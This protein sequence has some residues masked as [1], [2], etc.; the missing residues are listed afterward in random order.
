LSRGYDEHPQEGDR[1]S[2]E[3]DLL[4]DIWK[5]FLESDPAYSPNLTSEDT[6]FSLSDQPRISPL[7]KN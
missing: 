1:L 3:V 7:W 5:G 2:R 4:T 6:N